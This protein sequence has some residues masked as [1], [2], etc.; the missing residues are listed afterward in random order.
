[1]LPLA[2]WRRHRRHQRSGANRRVQFWDALIARTERHAPDLHAV[3][4]GG[5][6]PDAPEPAGAAI[7]WSLGGE[8][9]TTELRQEIAAPPRPAASPIC[10]VRPRRRSMRSADPV[11]GDEPARACRS[12]VRCRTTRVYVLD[13]GLEPA[14]AGVVG[15]LYIA[16]AGLARGYVGRADL[17][18]ERFVADPFGAAGSRMY[19]TGD[20]ARWRSDG[21]LEFAGRAD[22]QVKLRGFRIEPG[23]IEAQLLGVSRGVAG[24]GDCAGGGV[25]EPA[26]GGLCGGGGGGGPR[27]R[28][29]AGASGAAAAGLHGSAGVCG[30][31]PAA[32]DGE[33]QARPGGA[34]GARACGGAGLAGAARRLRRRSCA[35]CSPRCWVCR[36]SG[37]TTISSSWAV[38]RCWRPGWSA[39]SAPR[40]MSSLPSA[41][42]SRRRRWRR[43]P[44][45]LGDGAPTRSDFDVLLPLRSRGSR[46]ALFC[47][48]PAAGLSLPY[49]Q[50]R[51]PHPVRPSDLRPPVAH[52]WSARACSSTRS[53]TWPPNT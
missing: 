10:T 24:G 35:A 2:A 44:R 18:G 13:G 31:G 4:S 51:Q 15:E 39:A 23:E 49:S 25:G 36:G 43:S 50:T 32:A 16:G 22:A 6:I 12:A 46:S 52:P 7:I 9:F 14:P 37:S 5:V 29:A 38:I 40:S 17:T 30:S 34:A 21:V 3:A 45:R 19:R 42:C 1:M 26:A 11:A 8:T 53:R 48:H 27:C 47:I 28:G 20:L 33:R 41:A